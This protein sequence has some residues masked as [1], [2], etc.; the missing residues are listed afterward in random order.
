[1]SGKGDADV[2]VG[3]KDSNPSPEKGN[4]KESEQEISLYYFPTSFSSQKVRRLCSI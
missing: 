2:S 3:A 1:M 4:G